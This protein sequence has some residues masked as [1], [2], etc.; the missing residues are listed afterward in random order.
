M[1]ML[2]IVAVGLVL[3]LAVVACGGGG[4]SKDGASNYSPEPCVNGHESGCVLYEQ[5]DLAIQ[6]GTEGGS[7]P[8]L[9]HCVADYIST[10]YWLDEYQ[11][12][13]DAETSQ[14]MQIAAATC[15]TTINR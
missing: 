14:L 13:T 15:G 11:A 5:V 10:R 2:S 7:T 9:R 6:A 4:D 3:L 1:K 8:A 12:L